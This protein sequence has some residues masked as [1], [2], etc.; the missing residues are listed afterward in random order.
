MSEAP[1]CVNGNAER[2]IASE[3]N[4]RLDERIADKIDHWLNQLIQRYGI[5]HIRELLK[6]VVT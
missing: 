4:I 5:C 1:L 6:A 3:H 2:F